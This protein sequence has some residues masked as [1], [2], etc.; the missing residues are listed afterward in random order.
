VMYEIGR[1]GGISGEVVHDEDDDRPGD[2]PLQHPDHLP[3]AQR[4]AAAVDHSIAQGILGANNERAEHTLVDHRPA[5]AA[6]RRSTRRIPAT[7]AS[8]ASD[9]WIRIVVISSRSAM[10]SP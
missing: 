2:D 6:P 8:R 1:P 3:V 9:L 7:P 4:R 10:N 5:C